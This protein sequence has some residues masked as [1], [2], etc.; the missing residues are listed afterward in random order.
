MLSSLSQLLEAHAWTT[1]VIR[2][3]S[4]PVGL[5]GK[6]P[7]GFQFFE[8]FLPFPE[9]L[10]TQDLVQ[11]CAVFVCSCVHLSRVFGS[12]FRLVIISRDMAR[13]FSSWPIISDLSSFSSRSIS[14]ITLARSCSEFHS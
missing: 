12:S 7:C 11:H 3:V 8:P 4:G 1:I 9:L 2:R 10:V 14:S 5:S 13:L 6:M